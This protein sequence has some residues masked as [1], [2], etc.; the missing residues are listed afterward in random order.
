MARTSRFDRAAPPVAPRF[1]D[2]EAG[3][4]FESPA[5]TVTGAD[6]EAFASLTGD[7]HPVHLDDDFARETVF[8]RRIAH[9]MLVLSLALG[10]MP[11]DPARVAA[12]RRVSDA[13]FKAPVRLG[14]TIRVKWRIVEVR[15]LDARFGTVTYAWTIV[16]QAG[17]T[18]V[19]ARVEALWHRTPEAG[20]GS[21]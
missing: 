2:L 8:G 17:A 18:V 7:R 9:G 13:T 11:I 19:R 4:E 1:E 10:L 12:L 15:P 21:A 5:H 3:V 14:D 6:V 20:A 16:N